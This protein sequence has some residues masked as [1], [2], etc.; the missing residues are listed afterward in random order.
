MFL[1]EELTGIRLVRPCSRGRRSLRAALVGPAYEVGIE[2]LKDPLARW[3][4]QGS[5]RVFHL[6]Q[7]VSRMQK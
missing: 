6:Q 1:A 3:T 5:K 2:L 7:V 4:E